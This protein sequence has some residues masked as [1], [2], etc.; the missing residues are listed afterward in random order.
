MNKLQRIVRSVKAATRDLARVPEQSF[1]PPTSPTKP[2]IGLAL[3]G[4]FAR[5]IAH[6]GVLKVFQEENIPLDFIAG[7]SM[8]AAIGGAFASGMCP[9]E[10]EEVAALIKFRDFAR[11]TLSRFGLCTNDRMAGLLNRIFKVKTFEDLQ[12]PLAVAATDFLTGEAVIFRNGSLVDAVRASCAYPGY[13]LPVEINGRLLVDGLLAHPV[14]A[15]PLK[16]MGADR[17]IAVYFNSHW[18]GQAGPKHVIDVIGQCF[19]IAQSKMCSVWQKDADIVIEPDVSTFAYDSFGR[20]SDLVKVGEIAAR[21]ALPSIRAW[22][23]EPSPATVLQPGST[24]KNPRPLTG[25][26]TAPAA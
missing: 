24:V 14:P 6:I 16:E 26:A 17:V 20:A 10:I 4:G 1:A 3:G 18:V 23:A 9:K 12:I 2:K 13:F 7:T 8:G 22:L 11:W 5:G 21:A 25:P 15:T 19:S